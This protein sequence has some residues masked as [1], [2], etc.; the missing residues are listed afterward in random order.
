LG[1]GANVLENV[2]INLAVTNLFDKQ[3]PIVGNQ[4]GSTAFNAGNTYPSN[5]DALGRRF[6]VGVNLRF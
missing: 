3:P 2:K 1:L 6:N 4:V 5:Y